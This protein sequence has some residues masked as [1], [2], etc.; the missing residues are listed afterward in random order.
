MGDIESRS[1]QR[2]E[3]HQP[4][5]II[6]AITNEAFGELANI[7][8]GGLM[9]STGRDI[10]IDSIY[11]LTLQLPFDIEESKIISIGA[12]CLWC[13]NTENSSHYWAGFQ[14]IDISDQGQDQLKELMSHYCKP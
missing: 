9:I 14:I 6:D 10:P 1:Q 4:I 8:S 11:Q 7:S 5:P 13:R 2:I 3:L 12:D